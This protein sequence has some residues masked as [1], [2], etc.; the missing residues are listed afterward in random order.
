MS[1]RDVETVRGAYTEFNSGNPQGVLDV[2]VED[3]EWIE[4]GGGNA[5]SGTFNSP[6]SVGDDVF[7]A[8]PQYFDEFTAEPEN[9]DDQGD[10]IVVTGRFKGKAKSGAVLDAAFEHT[11]DMRDGKI[12]RL[13][14]KPE[15][16]AW[17]AA[18]S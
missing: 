16:E 7:S 4:P 17:T 3:V 12:A 15:Q 9:F 18:W 1:E 14:N 11:F 6:Q 2:L 8:I 10:R 13:E 5:P